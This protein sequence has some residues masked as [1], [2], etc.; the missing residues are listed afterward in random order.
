VG[1]GGGG[2]M[3]WNGIH[4]GGGFLDIHNVSPTIDAAMNTWFSPFGIQ[5]DLE[6][7]THT[8]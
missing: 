8:P 7:E 6:N 5:H 4:G 2:E 1:G 3:R